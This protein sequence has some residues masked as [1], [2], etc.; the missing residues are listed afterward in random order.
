MKDNQKVNSKEIKK[1]IV[2]SSCDLE[3]LTEYLDID[4]RSTIEGIFNAIFTL[5]RHYDQNKSRIDYL[6][7]LVHL[8]TTEKSSTELKCLTGPIMD[9]NTKISNWK[10]KDRIK[11]KEP[12]MQIQNILLEVNLELSNEIRNKKVKYLSF[13]IFEEKN[14]SLIEKFIED[15]SAILSNKNKDGENIFMILLKKYL[16]LSEKSYEEIEY[17]YHIILLFFNSK[18]AKELLREK[19]MYLNLVNKSKLYYKEHIIRVIELFNNT[20][21]ISLEQL[22]ERYHISF[23]FPPA[24]LEEISMFSPLSEERIN[25]LNQECVTIDGENTSCLDDALYIEKNAD[26]TYYLYIHITDIP[27]FIP[28]GSITNMEASKRGETLY[29]LDRKIPLYPEYISDGVCSL[30]EGHQRNVITSIF[31][32]DSNYQVIEGD[33]RFVKGLIQ[34]R[35][36]LTYSQADAIILGEENTSLALMLRRLSSFAQVRRKANQKK[37]RYREYQNTL[38]FDPNHESVKIDISPSANIVHESMVLENYQIG[39]YFKD[40]SLPYLYRKIDLPSDEFIQMQLQKVQNLEPSF[41]DNKEFCQRIRDSYTRAKYTKDPVYHQG[42]N[43]DCYSHSSSP[44]RR[45]ADSFNQYLLYGLIFSHD[46]SDLNIYKWEYQLSDLVYY[47]N[48]KKKENEV[49]SRHYNYL[50]SKNLIRKK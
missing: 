32:L 26:G 41:L 17:Y 27:S 19:N 23:S 29:L 40:K 6:I 2:D 28:Y 22:E 15:N 38:A 44:A 33:F 5:M 8:T 47:L 42:Q 12:L 30:I 13:L 37:E 9:L 31:H 3:D 21:T 7:Q 39:K 18:Y 24:I 1:Y 20:F 25:F 48:Q 50:A 45:Y 14:I 10:L 49:F 46:S 43:L 34:V 4:Y 36:K 16:Y 35:K 11:V